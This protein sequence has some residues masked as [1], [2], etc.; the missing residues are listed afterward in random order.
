M[1]GGLKRAKLE[2]PDRKNVSQHLVTSHPEATLVPN[3]VFFLLKVVFE[4]L[5]IS[6]WF[7]SFLY[8]NMT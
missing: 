5:V 1:N 4:N 2:S 6:L 8:D 3:L 7:R